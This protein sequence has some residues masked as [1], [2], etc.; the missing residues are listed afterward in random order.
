M[1]QKIVVA[2]FILKDGRA[3]LA[4]R[5]KTKRIGPDK[6]HLPGGH[7]EVGEDVKTALRREIQ[8]EFGILIDV[9][10]PFYSFTYMTDEAHTIGLVCKALIAEP[11]GEIVLNKE[12]EEIVWAS[13]S[14]LSNYLAADDYNLT[15]ARLGF[16]STAELD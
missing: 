14:D 11:F 6:F 2:G 10:E 9:F 13:E 12:T 15:A 4:K 1:L 3:L 7:V 5:P 16:A 8:E